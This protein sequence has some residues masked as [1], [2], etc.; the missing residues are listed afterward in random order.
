MNET[1]ELPMLALIELPTH[2]MEHAKE[3]GLIAPLR[4]YKVHICGGF[5][6]RT[7]SEVLDGIEGISEG[8][9]IRAIRC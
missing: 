9:F 2:I 7:D 8:V 1:M 5:D 3:R 4:G 6:R